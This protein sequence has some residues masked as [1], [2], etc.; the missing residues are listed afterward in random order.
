MDDLPLLESDLHHLAV[1]AAADQHGVIRLNGS[2]AGQNDRKIASLDVARTY[3]HGR[4]VLGSLVGV[5]LF[6][7]DLRQR[8]LDKRFD[9]S[10]VQ[11]NAPGEAQQRKKHQTLSKLAPRRLRHRA[12]L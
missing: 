2:E 4:H 9:L 12:S 6:R 10:P 8:A 3:R 1:D 7:P 5:L 11:I